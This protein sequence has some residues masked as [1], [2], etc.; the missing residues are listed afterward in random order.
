MA[1]RIEI[2]SKVIDARA[3]VRKN[4]LEVLDIKSQIKEITIVDVYTLDKKLDTKQVSL[5]SSTLADLVSQ[6][7]GKNMA[8]DNFSWA[9]E[10]GFLPGVTDNVA[11]STKEIVEDLLKTKFKSNEGVYTSQI[12]FF[13]GKISEKGDK[14][15]HNRK[16]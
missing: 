9:V 1:V 8:P 6:K 4:K 16:S 12:S 2:I 5:I 13:S 3:L 11:T 7:T 14:D 10:V 15:A